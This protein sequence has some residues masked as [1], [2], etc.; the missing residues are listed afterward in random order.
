[1]TLKEA[2]RQGRELIADAG[3]SAPRLTAEVLL[4]HALGKDRTWLYA[5]DDEELSEN[6]WIHFGRYLHQRCEGVPTQY[7]TK[8]QEFYG[9]EFR[10]TPAVLIPRPETEHAVERCLALGVKGAVLDA[11][12]GSGCIAVTLAL[13]MRRPVLACDLSREALEVA[14]GNAARLGAEVSFFQGDFAAGVAA[15]S[16]GLL[17]SNPPYVPRR[18]AANIQR[19]VRDHEPE[20]ALYGGEDG[21]DN[22]RRLAEDARRVLAPGGWLVC[23]LGFGQSEAVAALLNG[24]EAVEIA[25]DLAGIPRC[26]S[27]RWRGR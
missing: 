16:L 24:F 2:L 9:R 8:R 4:L 11:G 19:E 7:I 10:V 27:A 20:I 14:R 17:V 22:Y 21:L 12:T 1:M 5:H 23:E 13:E 25:P 18:D 3:V 26:L 15:E 6:A